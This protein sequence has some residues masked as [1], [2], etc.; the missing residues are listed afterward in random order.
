M[1][2]NN[3]FRIPS[4]LIQNIISLYGDAGLQWIKNLFHIMK[5]NGNLKR[6]IVF[7]THNLMWF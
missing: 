7:Q 4:I 2:K 5:L 6:M 1:R 3:N